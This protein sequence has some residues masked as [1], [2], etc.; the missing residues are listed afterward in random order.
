VNL[1]N[2]SRPEP[3]RPDV[4]VIGASLGGVLAAWRAAEAGATVLL[5]AEHPWIG[6]QMTA[7]AVPPDEHPA[8]EQGAASASYRR[9][10][11]A[12]RAL[13]RSR[14]GFRDRSTLTPGFTNPGDG[15]VSRLCLEPV[16]AARWFEQ[17]LAPAQ[18]EGR[19]RLLR[20]V[21]P[22]AARRTD[23]TL[24]EVRL[25][26]AADQPG[27]R[28]WVVRAAVFIDATDTGE[29]LKLAGLP[30]RL[31][32]EGA[33]DF[34]EPD[35]PAVAD[36]LD[37]QPCTHVL[38]LRWGA[39]PGPVVEPPPAYAFW[40]G[41][42]LPQ[43]GHLQFS[44]AM[45]GHGRGSSAQLPFAAPPRP[46]G[47][48]DPA[49]L[50][51]WRYRRVVSAA[52]W[53]PG[54]PGVPPVP[55]VAG[56]LGRDRPRHDVT[57]V[58]WPQNDYALHPL[59]DGPR[60]T[61]AVQAAA[62]ELSLCWLHWLQTEAP[63]HDGRGCGY[64]EWQPAT[65]LLGTRDGLAQQTYVRESRR[66]IARATLTQRHLLPVEAGADPADPADTVA[67]GAYNLD[68]H[69]T[70]VSGHGTNAAVGPFALP[71]GAFV[72]QHVD[73]LLP[74]CKNAGVTHLASACTRVHPAEW[75]VGEVA[76]LMAAQM[77]RRRLAAG[78]L[79]DRPAERAALLAA[80]DAAGVLRRWPRSRLSAPH[81]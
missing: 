12:M 62:R 45:P 48:P 10:R 63:R 52:Q 71:L 33:A 59:L 44:A 26:D 67:V 78:A 69:P 37:Q 41:H 20:L 60:P 32:K 7:Q 61:A 76:G 73:N 80:L 22:L 64:P 68:I 2:P 42:R 5:A 50:D 18:R 16:D 55:A 53:G 15:W 56:I 51:W 74:G 35:A 70:V 1:A 39:A 75:S 29:L 30:Y 38:A 23:A 81:P 24:R 28:Q 57:L 79:A 14:P 72:P 13:V 11:E 25:A 77:A 43:Y 58:N 8:V 66:I 36:P 27:A 40:R 17:L 54:G 3:L 21:R 4:A 47:G 31:G 49:V 34:G 9:F 6:G 19:L 46:D 65:D